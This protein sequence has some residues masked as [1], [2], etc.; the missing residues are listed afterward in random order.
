MTLASL[1][2]CGDSDAAAPEPYELSN[3]VAQRIAALEAELGP[4]P[5]VPELEAKLEEEVEGM[6]TMLAGAQGRMREVPLATIR[7][8][9][10][11]AAIPSLVRALTSG[12]RSA[13]ERVAAAELLATLTH[14]AATEALMQA[15]EQSLEPWMRRWCAYHLPGTGDDRVVPRL[16]QRLKYEKDPETFVWLSMAL[17]RYRNYSGIPA[18][19]DLRDRGATD[20]LRATAAGQLEV[21]AG[22]LGFAPEEARDLW[23]SIDAASLP[24]AEVSPALRLELWRLVI[25]LDVDHF[26]LRGVDDARY[27][28]SRMGPWA[29]DEVARAL[30]D[31]DGHVRLHCAQV[32]ERMGPRASSAGPALLRALAEPLLAPAAAEALGRVGHPPALK[33]LA[34]RTTPE[35][36]HELRVAAVRALGRL[37]LPGAI[38]A[39]SDCFAESASP[40]DLR[41]AAATA[42]VLLEQ[43][44][45]VAHWLATQLASEDADPDAAEIALETWLVRSVERGA[46]GFDAVLSEWRGLQGPPGIIPTMEAVR[47]RQVGRAKVMARMLGE[48]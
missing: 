24:Q 29:A 41:M 12:Q 31:E 37:G 42:M 32:L 1:C 5:R 19:L 23:N 11:A 22:D 36:D 38:P 21:L 27:V 7:E 10:G 17:A 48:E 4:A 13:D 25:E 6:V 3:V 16:I 33:A 44:E 20:N 46:D 28:L 45:E 18:L 47:K 40:A 26:Q 2:A 39:V 30:A 15:V 35:H 9:I 14:P 8:D 43:G 34:L